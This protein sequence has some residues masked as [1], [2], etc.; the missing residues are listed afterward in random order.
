MESS[1]EKK[2]DTLTDDDV[3]RYLRNHPGFFLKHEDL[4]AEI[5]LSQDTGKAVSLTERQV[6]ILRERNME[7]RSR[8]SGLLENAQR[9]DVLFEK[10]KALVLAL[11]EAKRADELSDIFCT[12]LTRNFD[13][14]AA[15]LVVFGNPVVSNS[16]LRVTSEAEASKYVGSILKNNKAICGILRDTEIAF[17]FGDKEVARVGSAAVVPLHRDRPLGLIAIGSK[18]PQHFQSSMDTLFLGYIAEVINRCLPRL[19]KS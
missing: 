3:A 13:I 17:L 10:T 12:H 2:T 15:G 6:S 19:L 1:T 9:N 14:D 8:L 4:L 11:V 5:K 18:D 7:M 16:R